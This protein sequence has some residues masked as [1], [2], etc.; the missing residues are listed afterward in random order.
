[1]N[2]KRSC[3]GLAGLKKEVVAVGGHN[4]SGTLKVFEAFSENTQ[5][6]AQ[7]SS[8]NMER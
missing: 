4:E 3:V 5:K 6:W 1:M 7:R 8:L 2:I